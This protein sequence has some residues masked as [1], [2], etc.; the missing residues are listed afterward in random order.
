VLGCDALATDAR[1]STNAARVRHRA[2]LLAALAIPLRQQPAAAWL[3]ALAAA[4][5][6][7][8]PINTLDRAMQDPAAVSRGLRM[9]VAVDAGSATVGTAASVDTVR[10]PVRE[11][12]SKD[13]GEC[14]MP[15]RGV[16]TLGAHTDEVLRTVSGYSPARL[17][18]LRTSGVIA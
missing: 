4:G 17:A 2:E 10:C 9:P 12:S 1:F 8:G 16:P 3:A 18:A 13:G 11:V 7:C 5:V 14:A 15:A 6:P